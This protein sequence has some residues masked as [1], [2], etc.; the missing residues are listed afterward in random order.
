MS[1]GNS[2]SAQSRVCNSSLV[3]EV[4]VNARTFIRGRNVSAG[5]DTSSGE[6]IR[7]APYPVLVCVLTLPSVSRKVSPMRDDYWPNGGAMSMLPS[8]S[9][10]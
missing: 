4:S 5:S 8:I 1:S 10:S 6:T 7:Y 9:Q 3:E 2:D